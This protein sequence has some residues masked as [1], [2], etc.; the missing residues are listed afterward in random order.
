MTIYNWDREIMTNSYRNMKVESL[1]QL[2]KTQD[3]IYNPKVILI[4]PRAQ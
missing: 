1:M 2:E 3:N 4:K